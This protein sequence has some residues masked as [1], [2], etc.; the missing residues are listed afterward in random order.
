MVAARLANIAHGGARRSDQAAN[1]PL[2]TPTQQVSQA[3]AAQLTN[4]SER[5]VRS[6]RKVVESGDENLA[7]AVDQ[8]RVAVSVAAK[9]ADL[10]AEQREKVLAAPAP[11]H[12]IKKVARQKKEKTLADKQRAMPDKKYGVIYAD[13]EWRFEVYSRESGMDRAADNHYPTTDTA[14]ICARDVASI[15]AD[16]CALFLWST[17]PML[18]DALAVMAAWGFAY[19]SRCVWAKDRLGTGYWF[20]DKCE[21]LLVGTRGDVPAPAM[22]DQWPSLIEAPVGEHSAKPE[23]FAEMIEAYFPRLPKIELNRRGPP[24]PGWDAWGNQAL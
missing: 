2:E 11:E 8:G 22:G 7:D 20:R 10:P 19:K 17:Q 9:I 12:A 13:P 4:V 6:A 15:A 5:S 1:L 16:D 23:I 3:R 18:P 14:G 24:R 21:I